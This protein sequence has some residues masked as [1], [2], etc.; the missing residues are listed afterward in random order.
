VKQYIYVFSCTSWPTGV[1]KVGKVTK[2]HHPASRAESLSKTQPARCVVEWYMEVPDSD[3]AEQIA[4]GILKSYKHPGTKEYFKIDL[5]QAV[6]LI[7]KKVIDALDIDDPICVE[8]DA[9]RSIAKT[10][11]KTSAPTRAISKPVSTPVIITKPAIQEYEQETED[12]SD[13]EVLTQLDRLEKFMDGVHA[14]WRKANNGLSSLFTK[15]ESG[16]DDYVM[17]L[18]VKKQGFNVV[19]TPDSRTPA[20]LF[21]LKWRGYFYHM[22]LLQ[23]RATT[24]KL[25]YVPKA[26]ELSAIKDCGRF[27]KEEYLNADLYEQY[28]DKPIVFSIGLATVKNHRPTL[29]RCT[30]ID[31]DLI[32]WYWSNLPR[33][34]VVRIK[35]L[36]DETHELR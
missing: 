30:L 27:V 9:L 15:P 3:F 24:K 2:G 13:D 12:I 31:S 29:N 1:V 32:N 35:E 10:V 36:V 23:V 8:G 11:S 21:G 6:A 28:A 34:K 14:K 4:H 20:D 26:K 17:N 16:A 25:A 5:A 22:I 33:E 19:A 18:L 7:K